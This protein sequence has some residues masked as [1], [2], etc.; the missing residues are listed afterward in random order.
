MSTPVYINELGFLH[1]KTRKQVKN[2]IGERPIIDIDY[3]RELIQC[4]NCYNLYVRP[5]ATITYGEGETFVTSMKC[6]KCKGK[7]EIIN[8]VE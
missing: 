1:H 6:S 2:V 7:G 3:E 8:E 4:T 5:V